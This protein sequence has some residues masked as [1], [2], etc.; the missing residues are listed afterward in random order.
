VSLRKHVVQRRPAEAHVTDANLRLL[1]LVEDPLQHVRAPGRRCGQGSDLLVDLD[2]VAAQLTEDHPGHRHVRGLRD[3]DLDPLPADLRLEL[4]RGPVGDHRAVVDDHDVVRQPV[5]LLH[6]LRGQQ[7][8]GTAPHQVVDGLPHLRPAAGVEAR[9]RLVEEQHLGPCHERRRQ[10]QPA[11]HPAAVRLGRPVG[12]VLERELLEQLPRPH[13]RA[14]LAELVQPPEHVEV[15]EPGQVL[16]DGRV[17][18]GQAD[19]LSDLV[20]LLGDVEPGHHRQAL[21]GLEQRGQDAH[22]RRLAG[23]VRARAG[24]APFPAEPPGRCRRAPSP[25]RTA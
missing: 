10:V 11:P 1:E 3:D 4:V 18:A 7:H 20:G 6:V 14:L 5:G 9:R 12:G 13:A 2:V 22:G 21:V 24:R 25:P 19:A 17:L 16:V 15:L 23:A 8:R